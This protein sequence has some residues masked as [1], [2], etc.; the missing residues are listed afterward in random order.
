[1]KQIK[2]FFIIFILSISLLNYAYSTGDDSRLKAAM[3]LVEISYNMDAAYKQF[4]YFGLL[5]AKERYENNLKTKKYSDILVGIVKEILDE[6][7]YDVDTQKQ[8][9][10]AYA[11]IYSE[12]FTEK[13]LN[14]MIAFY[15]TDTG[16]KVI[17][18]LP[19][20][21]ERGRQKEIELVDLSLSSPKYRQHLIDKVQK[22]QN[23]GTLP[24]EF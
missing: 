24:K 10:M 15:K 19:F 9:K 20:V 18:K 7:F 22:L 16:K 1:M 6:Y 2:L 8:L 21:I 5:P 12:I 4:I 17:E 11:T 14:E 13:E 23:D 3:N